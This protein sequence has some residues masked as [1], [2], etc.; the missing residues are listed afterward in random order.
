MTR[1]RFLRHAGYSLVEVLLVVALIGVISAITIPMTANTI[2]GFRISGDSRSVANDV[3]LAK[4][5]AS[6]I[7]T[8][9]RFRIDFAP[10]TYHLETWDKTTSKWTTDG[11]TTTLSSAV[12]FGFGIV[13]SAPPNTQPVICA[14]ALCKDDA[15]VDVAG[16][17][18]VIF[19]SRGVPVDATGSPTIDAVYI[20][21]GSAVYG[22]TV[23]A[24]GMI[25]TWRTLPT[26]KPAW[27]QQ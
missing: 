8:K 27:I 13:G 20:T 26:A 22:V 3:A 16:T 15:G 1:D 25:R 5:R 10:R 2:A 12:S 21:D 19:N 23:S 6:S 7:F 18:C 24:T 17:Y 4:M 11:G 14:P 9:V